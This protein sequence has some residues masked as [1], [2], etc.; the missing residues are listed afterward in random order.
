MRPQRS[1]LLLCSIL[2]LSLLAGCSPYHGSLRYQDGAPIYNGGST[3]DYSTSES[4]GTGVFVPDDE[5]GLIHIPG[6]SR[7]GTDKGYANAQEVRLKARELAAQMIDVNSTQSI[8]G[9]VALP[10]SFVDLNNLTTSTP[11]GRYLAEAMFYEF[12]QRNVPVKEYRLNKSIQP[13]EGTGELALRRIQ[14]YAL[15]K[16]WVAVLVGTYVQDKDG[17]F[18]NARLV[19]ATDGT[20]LRTGSMVL[21][22]NPLVA[23]LAGSS[24]FPTGS[25]KIVSGTPSPAPTPK[26]KV[27][28]KRRATKRRTPLATNSPGLAPVQSFALPN[29]LDMQAR[30]ASDQLSRGGNIEARSAESTRSNGGSG[31]LNN[32]GSQNN[33][34]TGPAPTVPT[35]SSNFGTPM[36]GSGRNT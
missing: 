4:V 16:G 6:K 34:Y 8:G 3:G 27:T 9:M 17:V 12:N 1:R 33:I 29:T 24:A 23:R 22:N 10:T 30:Q 15:N 7:L 13:I 21:Q 2:G 18:V 26:K 11:L 25:M 35:P 14:P 28:K 31:T 20:V 19:R 5:G 36:P 32:Q